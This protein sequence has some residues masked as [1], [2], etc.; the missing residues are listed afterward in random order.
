MTFLEAIITGVSRKKWYK[1]N[2]AF[3]DEVPFARQS[4]FVSTVGGGDTLTL[5]HVNLIFEFQNHYELALN[6]NKMNRVVDDKFSIRF[7]TWY[8]LFF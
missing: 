5:Q 3:S 6:A 8:S 1:I 4:I 2:R 7:F